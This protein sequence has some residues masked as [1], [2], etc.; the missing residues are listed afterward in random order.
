MTMDAVF[1]KD[2]YR[3]EITWKRQTSNNAVVRAY[4]RNTD[5]ILFY[6]PDGA[7][8]NQPY[9]E[10][11]AAEMKE[12]RRDGRGLYK[13]D[14]LTTPGARADR[15]FTWR[16]ATPSAS[17]SWRR[18][19]AGLE[20]MLA[21]GEIELGKDGNAKL[22]GWKRYLD[23]MPT[24]QK[25]QMLWTDIQRVGNTAAERVGYPTQKP[26]ALLE[27]IVKASS[28]EGDMVLD[29]FAGCA[30]ACVAAEK[31]ER[32]WA[33]IDISPKAADLV[34]SRLRGELGLFYRSAHRTDIP[35]R[36]DLGGIPPYNADTNKH[37][38]YGE[39]E[40]VCNGCRVLFPYRNLTI[41]HKVPQS[42]GG[43]DAIDNLQLLCA[44]CNSAK[45]SGTHEA[46]IAKLA[47]Q[48]IR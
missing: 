3:N 43:G 2:N 30:T 22:R 6:A 26:L 36:T 24:G 13:V 29:P 1:G 16:G 20:A 12:Y 48:G 8:W 42:K 19:E 4:G 23:E 28:N 37:R 9:F 11:S 14:N 46:L 34:R 17:R 44:A 41:D 31:L 40:G 45:G 15:Q 32:Q 7:T 5:T 25:A 47:A 35:T 27:R 21:R 39:Q 33:G 10:R 18:D 38:L